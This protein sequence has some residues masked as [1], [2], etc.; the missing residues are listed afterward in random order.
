MD[1]KTPRPTW[2]LST[3]DDLFIHNSVCFMEKLHRAIVICY[4]VYKNILFHNL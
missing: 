3:A 4:F 1:G 2:A